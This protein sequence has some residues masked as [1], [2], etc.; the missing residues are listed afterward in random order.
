MAGLPRRSLAPVDVDEPQLGQEIVAE[1]L[2]VSWIKVVERDVLRRR[3]DAGDLA[4]RLPVIFRHV[5]DR[6]EHA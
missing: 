5:S 3:P 6:T 2:K 4:E 1:L